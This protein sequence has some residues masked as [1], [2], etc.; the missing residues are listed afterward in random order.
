MFSFT[1]TC[2][3]KCY[4]Q[5]LQITGGNSSGISKQQIASLFDSIVLAFWDRYFELYCIDGYIYFVD[6]FKLLYMLDNLKVN[7]L[8]GCFYVTRNCKNYWI[9]GVP[10]LRPGPS[11]DPGNY[12]NLFFRILMLFDSSSE[13]WIVMMMA[14]F[15]KMII[16]HFIPN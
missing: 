5:F 14:S 7:F 11:I 4:E 2:V 16:N 10:I 6:F 12:M 8:N 1:I 13:F 9:H 15:R 3:R